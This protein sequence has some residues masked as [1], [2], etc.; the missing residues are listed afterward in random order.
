MKNANDMEMQQEI[1]RAELLL[2]ERTELGLTD[3]ASLIR[4]VLRS[5][6]KAKTEDE[7]TAALESLK[8]FK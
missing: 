2:K 6:K 1:E 8:C 4:A 3:S 5:A 7:K